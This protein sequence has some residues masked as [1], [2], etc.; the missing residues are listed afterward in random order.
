MVFNYETLNESLVGLIKDCNIVNCQYADI[1][2]TNNFF[3]LRKKGLI[4]PVKSYLITVELSKITMSIDNLY[5]KIKTLLEVSNVTYR[6]YDSS[7]NKTK[8]NISFILVPYF[9]DEININDRRVLSSIMGEY[10]VL[11]TRVEYDLTERNAII[12]DFTYRKDFEDLKNYLNKKHLD[13]K[14]L[15]WIT[16]SKLLL[17]I[18]TT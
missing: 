16:K 12:V 5:S 2:T 7:I 17:T 8:N 18:K 3:L 6:I 1:N 13:Y 14:A 9:I 11:N 10:H 4:N 15:K